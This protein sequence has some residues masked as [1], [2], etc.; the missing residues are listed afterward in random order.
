MYGDIK[1]NILEEDEV[2]FELRNVALLFN[3]KELEVIR[4]ADGEYN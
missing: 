2:I 4:N 1:W 3:S